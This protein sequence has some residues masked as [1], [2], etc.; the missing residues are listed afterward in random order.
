MK[1][2]K[3]IFLFIPVLLFSIF[4][5]AQNNYDREN[6]KNQTNLQALQ[7][8]INKSNSQ[9]KIYKAIAFNQKI[10]LTKTT[11][12]GHLG[13]FYSFNENGDPV[14]AY[15]DNV[16]AATSGRT[17]KIWTGGSSGLNLTGAGIQIG[18]W[19]SGRAST[20]HQ[21][22]KGRVSSGDGALPTNHGTHTGGTLIGKGV[23][24][25]AR[26]MASE[27]TIKGYTASG[28][29]AEAASFAAAGGILANNSNSPIG[30]NGVYDANAR[31][32]DEVTYNAPFYLHCKSAGNNGS[33]Y[34]SVYG[35]QLAKN[36]FVVANS[37]DVLNYTGP[38]SVTMA[39]SSSYGPSND[40]RI[41]PDITNNGVG[42]YSSD[43]ISDTSYST[44]TGTSMS[45]P[46]TTGTIALLQ[47]HYKNINGTYMRAATA[48]ALIIDT[49]DEVGANDGPDFR[50]G[51]GLVNAERA[52]QVITNNGN[53]SAI[54]ELVL[55]NGGT[56]TKT[57]TSDGVTPLA[58][59]IAWNDPAGPTNTG[60]NPILVNDL[61]MRV[62]GNNNTYSPW[63]MVPNGNFNNYTDAA[64]KGDNYR[65]NVEKIDAVLAA[66]TYTVTV[67]H[68][69]ALTNGA[70]DFS[71]VINGIIGVPDTQA[72]SKPTNLI[73]SNTGATSTNLS[74]VASTDNV[75]VS[76]YKI[77]EG[78]TTIGTSSTTNFNVT[79]LSANTT[80]SFTVKAKDAAGNLSENSNIVNVITTSTPACTGINS[81]PYSE[82]FESNLGAWINTSG[83]DIEWTRGSGGTPS[84]GT[85]PSTGQEGSFYLYTEASTNVTPPGSPNK[86][87]L[88][89]SPCI[90]LSNI[91]NVSLDFGYHMLGTAMGSLQVLIS[92]DNGVSYTSIWSQNGSQGNI[93]NQASVSLTSY[94]GS[95]IQL[96]FKATT[97]TG[98]SSDIAIDTIK[99]ISDTPDN[100]APTAPTNL[101]TA[102]I[103]NTTLDL[104]WNASTDNVAV[105]EYDVYERN[106]VIATTT[107]TSYQATGLTANTSYSFRIKAKDANDNQSSFS[108]TSIAI[109]LPDIGGG[110]CTGIS[111]YVTGTSYNQGEEVQNAGGKYMCNIPGWCSSTAAWAYAPGTGLYWQDAWSKTGNCSSNALYSLFP[112]ITKDITSLIIKTENA[113]LIKINL[114]D[115]TGKLIN[116]QTYQENQ[117]SIIQDLSELKEGLY[118]FKIY[119]DN[120]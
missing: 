112:T 56:Y 8:I 115:F 58:I 23:D 89:N 25:A 45:T 81:F 55:N 49:A 72:P 91:S 13:V 119:I 82:S 11:A 29:V 114:Y 19:E 120:N 101:S 53:T 106:T 60:N 21:E 44:K 20:T 57:F 12:D 35:N 36:L 10:S 17:D 84:S 34:N 15:D 78:T 76:E 37:N 54:E 111:K 6:I 99:I 98:W 42:V 27:A 74:W 2:R 26:G 1:S 93:W 41:K 46:A 87:A 107:G 50:S 70:Q 39:S 110:N 4:V 16:D 79:G 96:Q 52:A 38:S 69:G 9:D 48:K 66:G 80:Y 105:T 32:M 3:S 47:Q 43:A 90:D 86:I 14:Y 88:L 62:T 40:W 83:D 116:S 92:T 28:M 68:K 117:K 94:T 100:Q 95:V 73:A 104:S 113:S 7:K 109:T 102:N 65:D 61:D 108:N 24:P 85:G 118:I 5:N 77:F 103:T 51:W 59:T 97:G 18:V 30:S 31:D 63:V 64:Q 33:P 67:T 22:L 75:R 71:L